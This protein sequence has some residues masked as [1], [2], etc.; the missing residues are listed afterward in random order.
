MDTSIRFLTIVATTTLMMGLGALAKKDKGFVSLFNGKDLKGW[1][2]PA[3]T[4]AWKVIDGVIDYEAKGGNLVTE[5][6]FGDYTLRLDWRFK[7]TAGPPYN[8]KIFDAE[9]NQKKGKDGKPMTKPVK[10]ADSGIFVRGSGNSQVNLWCWPCGSGHLW[11]FHQSDN[12]SIRKGAMPKLN[13]DKPVGEWNEMEITM[14]GETATVIMNEKTVID[15]SE[16]PGV[17]TKGPIVLQ[18]HGGYDE[19]NKTW[20]SASALIQFRNI[21][22]K[23]L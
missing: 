4:H 17:G 9:G 18:H 16:M 22:I 6:S 20:S 14:K 15:R 12:P 5:K 19:K 23:A 21:K 2:T 10:N 7:R 11:A 1:K 3:G 8:A 13:A